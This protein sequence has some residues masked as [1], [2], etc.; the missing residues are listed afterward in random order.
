MVVAK[1]AVGSEYIYQ[2]PVQKTYQ[3]KK[4][5]VK[6]SVS[7]WIA[8]C[9]GVLL[10]SLLFFIGL[11]YTYLKASKARMHLELSQM[12]QVNQQII[13]Q[14]EKLRLETEKLKSLDR[15]EQIASLQMGMTK[16]PEVNYLVLDSTVEVPQ[17]EDITGAQ[18]DQKVAVNASTGRKIIEGIVGALKERG[19]GQKG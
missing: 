12:E 10:I 16:N 13:W 4:I 2:A 5:R 19:I 14:N 1:R 3:K 8:V 9:S 6:R 18:S 15:I 7:A 11:S 17:P